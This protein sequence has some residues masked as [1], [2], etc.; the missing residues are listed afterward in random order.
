MPIC[1]CFLFCGYSNFLIFLT[2][3]GAGGGLDELLFVFFI[4]AL[5]CFQ[6]TVTDFNSDGGADFLMVGFLTIG[7]VVSTPTFCNSD[8]VNDLTSFV[9]F[10]PNDLNNCLAAD[11]AADAAVFVSSYVLSFGLLLL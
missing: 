1:C 9:T 8:F 6:S 11:P 2:C 5:C 7:L 4:F 10:D 3:C